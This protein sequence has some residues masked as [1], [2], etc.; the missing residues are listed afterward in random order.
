MKT[1]VLV[2][3]TK[4]TMVG[5]G[6]YLDELSPGNIRYCRTAALPNSSASF[7]VA[8]CIADCFYSRLSY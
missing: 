3:S 1:P 8:D 6:E 2:R 4:L 7:F 5:P